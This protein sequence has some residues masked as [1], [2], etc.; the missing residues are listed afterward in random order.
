L[1]RPKIFDY[2]EEHKVDEGRVHV[3]LIAKNK[4]QFQ[5][6]A[7]RGVPFPAPSRNS[8]NARVFQN[9]ITIFYHDIGKSSVGLD[10]A[11]KK[12]AANLAFKSFIAYPVQVENEVVCSVN[13]F[14]RSKKGP[15]DQ[16]SL[17]DHFSKIENYVRWMI[18][19]WTQNASSVETRALNRL[20]LDVYSHPVLA[21][22]RLVEFLNE[23]FQKQ[24]GVMFVDLRGFSKW[25]V[26]L[27][28]TTK[29]ATK[30]EKF[31][32]E[33]HTSMAQI[34]QEKYGEF[35]KAMGDGLMAL[36]G[37]LFEE[38]KPADNVPLLRA[39]CAG[40][41]M[42]KCFNK[43]KKTLRTDV[44]ALASNLRL[45]IGINFGPAYVSFMGPSFQTD[46]TAIIDTVN[47]A[48]KAEEK[49]GRDKGEIANSVRTTGCIVLPDA[50]RSCMATF[51]QT[52]LLSFSDFKDKQGQKWLS[53]QK[54]ISKQCSFEP[55]C[56]VCPF[57]KK[58]A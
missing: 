19:A 31:L 35:D 46:F 44:K 47:Q 55:R 29:W 52:G 6:V 18:N 4:G 9:K 27:Q 14:F 16:T 45:G 23:P 25:V 34:V 36:F 53:V 41:A 49:S 17:A 42:F 37:T 39:I 1:R 15:N 11:V 50:V 38:G 2:L 54:K 21:K 56:V 32:K 10:Q 33:Y 30:V 20:P 43:L 8:V 57:T 5:I 13:I 7:Q 12:A 48:Q 24:I 40:Q 58:R 26:S 22:E 3:S 28:R 51:S